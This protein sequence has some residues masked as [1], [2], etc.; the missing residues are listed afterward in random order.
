MAIIGNIPYFQ[1]N[2]YMYIQHIYIHNIILY[3]MRPH[4]T[5]GLNNAMVDGLPHFERQPNHQIKGKNEKI[6]RIC[7]LWGPALWC[8]CWFRFTP[9]TI[10]IST[11]NHSEIGVISQLTIF[12]H[13]EIGVMFTNLAI[14]NGGPTLWAFKNGWSP[15]H[16]GFLKTSRHD[17]PWRLDALGYP[18]DLRETSFIMDICC[19][20]MIG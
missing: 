15:C 10:V 17:H 19:G 8:E 9:V 14:V 18:H 11:I 1:T 6:T 7:W 20:Y 12:Y 3:N 4:L 5:Y 2:P 16:H 13:S